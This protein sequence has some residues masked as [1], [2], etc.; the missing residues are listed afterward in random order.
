MIYADS[1]T[2]TARDVQGLRKTSYKIEK[3]APV[4]KLIDRLGTQMNLLQ[5]DA[6]GRP[7]THHARLERESRK[8]HGSE[9]VG[10]A[11]L[12]NDE[13]RLQSEI[14]AGCSPD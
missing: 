8:L 12:D 9:R 6:E 3:D 11:L 1:I 14:S 4:S 13:I 7:I 5:E 10:D 2:I